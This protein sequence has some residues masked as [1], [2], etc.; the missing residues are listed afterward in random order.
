MIADVINQTICTAYAHLH[1]EVALTNYGVD[2]K[3]DL[4]KPYLVSY[5]LQ[6]IDYNS[7]A[8]AYSIECTINSINKNLVTDVICAD[9]SS[10]ADVTCSIAIADVTPA[11]STCAPKAVILQIN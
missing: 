2:C 8:E 9:V 1:K 10:F 7:C 4:W 11:R 3:K 5:L 6:S